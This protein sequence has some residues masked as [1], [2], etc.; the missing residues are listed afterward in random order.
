MKQQT[1]VYI[2]QERFGD[3]FDDVGVFLT[4]E[5]VYTQIKYRVSLNCKISTTWLLP[6][7]KEKEK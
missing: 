5:E 6:P 4:L 2:L 3:G 7:G 1:I